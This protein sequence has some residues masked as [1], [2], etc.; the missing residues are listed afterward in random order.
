MTIIII[1]ILVFTILYDVN[2][3]ATT[4][5]ISTEVDRVRPARALCLARP[6]S[7]IIVYFCIVYLCYSIV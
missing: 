7:A 4:I 6:E 2:N 3:D 1:I 5:S